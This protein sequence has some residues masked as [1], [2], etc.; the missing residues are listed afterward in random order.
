M[1]N[2]GRWLL[3]LHRQWE[4][5]GNALFSRLVR[6]GFAQFGPQAALGV[7]AG[8]R[9]WV[10]ADGDVAL[11]GATEVAAA[12]GTPTEEPTEEPRQQPTEEPTEVPSQQ[13]T[14]EPTKNPISYIPGQV[15]CTD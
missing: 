8:G 9:V 12:P 5:S 13:P 10:A 3:R 14:E 7:L 2:L 4:R 6:G 11:Q 15:I 1:G